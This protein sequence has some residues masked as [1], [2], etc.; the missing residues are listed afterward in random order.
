MQPRWCFYNMVWHSQ[1][2]YFCIVHQCVVFCNLKKYKKC[3]MQSSKNQSEEKQKWREKGGRGS[4][5][6]HTSP[7]STHLTWAPPLDLKPA[8]THCVLSVP[9]EPP[10]PLHHLSFYVAVTPLCC[11]LYS[12]CSTDTSKVNQWQRTGWYLN[13]KIKPNSDI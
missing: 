11:L 10:P 2:Q 9:L 3:L 7:D 5:E 13:V 6:T 8:N 4:G 12:C 1:S